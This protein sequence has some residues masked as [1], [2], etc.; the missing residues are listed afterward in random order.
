MS[1]RKVLKNNSSTSQADIPDR[2]YFT[3]GQ[4][5]KLCGLKTHIQ[6][7]WEQEFSQLNPVK[8]GKNRRYYTRKDIQLVM[9][10]QDLVYGQ[11]FTTAGVRSK[12]TVVEEL[13]KTEPVAQAGVI[14]TKNVKDLIKELENICQMLDSVD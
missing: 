7:Y 2:L 12:L 1:N 5:G 13:P 4:V 11:G 9:K 14:G 10:I 3:I 8:R 6:R